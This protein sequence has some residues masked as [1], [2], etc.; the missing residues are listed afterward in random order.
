MKTTYKQKLF[1]YFVVIFALFT[2]GIFLFEQSR[3]RE[4]KTEALEEKLDAYANLISGELRVESGELRVESG[5]LNNSQFSI[6]NSQLNNNSQLRLTLID[7]Q[8][9]VLYDNE[10]KETFQMEN[11]AQRP[12]IKTARE[13]G[14]GRDIRVSLSN[15][16]EYLY[17]AKRFNDYYIRVALPYDIQLRHFLKPDNFFLY[18]II[19]FFVVMLFL[20]NYVSNRFGK[21]IQQLRDFTYLIENENNSQLSTLNSQ[22]QKDELGEISKKIVENYLQLKKNKKE[23][24]LERE[25]LLQHVHSSEEGLCFFAADKSVEFYNGLFIQ[26][27]N[28]ITDE[29]N[30]NPQ[31]VL[32]DISFERITSFIAHREKTDTYF[33]TQISK[34]GRNFVVRVNTFDDNSFEIIINDITKQEKMRQMKQEMTGNIT[35]ELRTPVTGIRGCLETILEHP[36]EPQKKQ[37]FIESAYQQVLALSDLIQDMSLITKIEEA[38]QS[39]KLEAVNLE[40]LLTNLKND[41]EIFLQEKNIKIEWNLTG[42]VIVN[43]NRNLLYS[44]FRNLTDNAIRYAGTNV[45]ISIKKYN[46]DKDFYYFSYSDSGI[47]IAEEQ[48]LS[49]LFERFYRINEGRTRDTGGSG[50]GLSIVKNAI[51]FHKGTIVAKNKS[52]GGLEFL[53][54]LGKES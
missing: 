17:Y 44:I 23:I 8:G 45:T 29:A 28:T 43:G 49:R 34:Q 31:S 20:I 46:E 33:E 3:E 15:D 22:F 21:S 5:E 42:N 18:F 32:T 40:N 14:K 7:R 30:S 54:T 11:H 10:I 19:A 36:L 24:A 35:H 26:Y 52:G 38:P 12:E 13:K 53:F 41:L 37:Y 51:A 16:K 27:L 2:I 6:L 1:L 39:F 25:K 50:L 9:N 48:H 4:H 47:G